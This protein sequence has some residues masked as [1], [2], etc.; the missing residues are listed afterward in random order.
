MEATVRFKRCQRG[1]VLQQKARRRRHH[2]PSELALGLLG[3][4]RRRFLQGNGRRTGSYG[5]GGVVVSCR[6]EASS[7]SGGKT[8]IVVGAGVNGLC[9][10]VRLLESGYRVKCIAEN[11]LSDPNEGVVS[12]GA[13]GLWFPYLCESTERTG[14]WANETRKVFEDMLLQKDAHAH[15]VAVKECWQCYSSPADIEI[16]PWASDCPTFEVMTADQ[17]A[18]KYY[19]SKPQFSLLDQDYLAY[20]FEAPIVQVDLFL[21][22][23]RDKVVRMGGSFV[24][25]KVKG[26]IDTLEADVVVNCA[27]LG[28]ALTQEGLEQDGRMKPVR[29]Q[30]IHCKN[31][32]NITQAVTLSVG[33][34]SAYVIPRG[35][36]VIYGGTSDE[37]QWDLTVDYDVVADIIRRCK[38]LLPEEYTRD[39]T[40][41]IVGHWVGLRPYREDKVNMERKILSDGRMFVNNYGHGG[42]GFTLCW[43]CADEVVKL[44]SASPS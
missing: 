17:V 14:R 6:A 25:E 9:T 16:P 32:K 36:V 41:D 29:G 42:S 3:E 15:G 43:G 37:N 11:V 13:G 20:S 33:G 18:N 28:N 30:I 35:D 34:E 23:L 8:A 31:N 5:E 10:S 44:A 19:P 21:S 2:S 39:M 22:H 26:A 40:R 24:Q 4:K 12:G 38:K 27:G 7:G 1:E